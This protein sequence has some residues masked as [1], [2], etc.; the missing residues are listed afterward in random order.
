MEVKIKRTIAILL[1]VCFFLSITAA[2]VSAAPRNDLNGLRVK[3]PGDPKIYLVDMG[4]KRWIPNPTVYNNLFRNWDGVREEIAVT[5]IDTG[6]DIPTD[7]MLFICRDS[8]KVFLLDM[9]NGQFVK[10]WVTSPA[11]MDKYYFNWDKIV[12]LNFP[13]GATCP[14]GS[15]II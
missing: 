8:G 11:A 2:T 1:L 9:Q 14:T 12:K 7:A 4:Q 13:E 3:V 10:R 15:D 6:P 5:S